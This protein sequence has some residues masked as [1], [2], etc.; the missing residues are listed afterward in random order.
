MKKL[1]AAILSTVM[2]LTGTNMQVP[3]SAQTQTEEQYDAFD[4]SDCPSDGDMNQDGMTDLTDAQL[5]LDRLLGKSDAELPAWRAGDMNGDGSLNA[6]DLSILKQMLYQKQAGAF[7]TDE[8]SIL[9]IITE[10]TYEKGDTP[11]CNP[12]T[13]FAGWADDSRQRNM[14]FSLVYVKNSANI[15]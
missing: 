2:L 3:A 14:D 9:R 1:L 12:Y 5:L 7:L 6:V 4:G 13:G 8:K 10:L 15:I 11:E